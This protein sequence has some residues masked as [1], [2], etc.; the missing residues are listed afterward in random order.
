YGQ[1]VER[2]SEF[3]TELVKAQVDV[4]AAGGDFGIRAAQSATTTIPIVG[5]TDDMV[6]ARL[7]ESLARPG[8]NTTGVSLLAADLDG[9]RQDL[10]IEAVPGLRRIATFAD[11][12]TSA[13]QHLQDLESA[14]R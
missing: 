5:F 6:G 11:S 3:A 1:D 13:P 7:V 10:L 8:G 12:T 14:A 9:K 4:I 2:V